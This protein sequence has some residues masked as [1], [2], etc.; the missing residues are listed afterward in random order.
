MRYGGGAGWY[1]SSC[2]A[3]CRLAA[4]RDARS[5]RAEQ[6]SETASG[7]MASRRAR[8]IPPLSALFMNATGEG[9]QAYP[10][11]TSS[12]R[13]KPNAADTGSAACA[14]KGS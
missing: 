2:S 10:D 5:W 7:A 14:A 8:A 13:G 6:A 9:A 11:G 3:R 12:T 4:G 1:H